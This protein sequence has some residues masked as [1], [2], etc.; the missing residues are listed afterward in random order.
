M[1]LSI[2]KSWFAATS[3]RITSDR[4]AGLKFANCRGLTG[5]Q[6]PTLVR[7]LSKYCAVETLRAMA[8]EY[9]LQPCRQ[10]LMVLDGFAN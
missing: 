1:E 6:W 3:D 2:C 7:V 4:L 10:D 9:G 8:E 5:V